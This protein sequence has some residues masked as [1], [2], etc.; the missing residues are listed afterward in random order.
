MKVAIV[1]DTHGGFKPLF[2]RYKDKIAYLFLDKLLFTFIH[3][4][5]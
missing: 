5:N 4:Y 1:A 3:Y 2:D